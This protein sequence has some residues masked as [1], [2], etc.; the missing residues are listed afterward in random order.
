LARTF[1]KAST[2]EE[3]DWRWR[4]GHDNSTEDGAEPQ[5]EGTWRRLLWMTLLSMSTGPFRRRA[6]GRPPC[7]SSGFLRR[8][9]AINGFLLQLAA[10]EVARRGLLRR[11]RECC[12]RNG[13]DLLRREKRVVLEGEDRDEQ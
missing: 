2:A 4:R 3:D 10:N 11:R 6:R 5:G 13:S 8:E 12:C 9:S 7:C 1:Y